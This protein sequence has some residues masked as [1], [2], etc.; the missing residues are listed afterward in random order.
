MTKRVVTEDAGSNAFVASLAEG[1]STKMGI[2]HALYGVGATCAPL[3][4]TQWMSTHLR[5]MDDGCSAR[6]GL[7]V[8]FIVSCH[9]TPGRMR[10]TMWT[11][12]GPR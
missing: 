5:K 4:S 6:K 1:T 2:M 8:P 12:R 3:L 9:T 10:D 7:R 11:T